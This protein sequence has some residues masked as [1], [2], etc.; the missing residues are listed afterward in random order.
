MWYSPFKCNSSKLW[1][2]GPLAIL[3]SSNFKQE[4]CAHPGL[5]EVLQKEGAKPQVG[6]VKVK[7]LTKVVFCN[8]RR[9]HILTLQQRNS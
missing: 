6:M 9:S 1:E 5:V 3:E 4:G 7:K 8:G 2:T